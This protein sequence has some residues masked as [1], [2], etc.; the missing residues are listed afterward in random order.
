M[1]V[2]GAVGGGGCR[3]GVCVFDCTLGDL[4]SGCWNAGATTA[5]QIFTSNV[6][7]IFPKS[8]PNNEAMLLAVVTAREI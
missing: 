4:T 1:G 7:I 2:N 3:D 5:A 8:V 6:I